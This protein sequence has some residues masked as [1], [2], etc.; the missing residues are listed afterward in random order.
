MMKKELGS[1]VKVALCMLFVLSLC[2]LPSCKKSEEPEAQN[3][4]NA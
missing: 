2:L 4:V 3:A 1:V